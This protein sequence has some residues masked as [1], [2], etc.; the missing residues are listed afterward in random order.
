MISIQEVDL[1]NPNIQVEIPR[2]AKPLRL[3]T[4][5]NA[6]PVLL[7]EVP[8]DKQSNVTL[9]IVIRPS[10]TLFKKDEGM[11]YMGSIN[12]PMSKGKEKPL[13]ILNHVFCKKGSIII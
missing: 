4:K 6:P 3:A 10:F 13:I 2:N 1:L 12:I 9:F 11:E 8:E 5:V 7:L